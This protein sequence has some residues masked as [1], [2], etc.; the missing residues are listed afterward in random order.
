VSTT[1]NRIIPEEGPMNITALRQKH[2]D[3]LAKATALNDKIEAE[4]RP[5]TAEETAQ[6]QA[7]LDDAKVTKAAITTKEALMDA[8]RTAPA[9]SAVVVHN[10]AEDKPYASLGEQLQLLRAATLNPRT[11]DARIQAALG[12]SEGVAADG[13]ILIDPQ[14]APGILQRVYE[15]SI[16]ADRC[17]EMPMTSASLKVKAVDE[18]SRVDGSRWGGILG[19]WE[20]EA[21]QY[22]SSKPKFRIMDMVA[23]KLTALIYATEEVQA[24]APALEAY[25]SETVPLELAYKLDAAIAVGTGAGQP[26]GFQ[27]APATI[28]VAKDSGQATGTVSTNNVLNMLQRLYVRSRKTAAF[29]INPANEYLLYPL[30]IGTGTAVRLIYTPPGMN[31]NGPDFGTLLG[32]PVIPIEQAAAVGTQ[33]D[34]VLAD[35]KSYLLAKRQGI[36]ADSSIHVAFLTGEVAFRWM[37]R[38]DGQPMWNLPL[39]PANGSISTSPFVALAARP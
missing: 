2:T 9:V 5:P 37:M 31:G 36:R 27:N 10:R 20:G 38:V 14:F 8:E 4:G 21:D 30:T 12:Q 35:L 32:V 6:I 3:T 33:G 17:T 26:L 28:V 25:N 24:D 11:A 19:F 16:L 23:H 15:E 13:G 7:Y 22:V 18:R 39:T 34:F 29:F 1:L